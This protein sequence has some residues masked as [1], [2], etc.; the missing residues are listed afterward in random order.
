MQDVQRNSSHGDKNS[1]NNG[2]NHQGSSTQSATPHSHRDSVSPNVLTNGS[3]RKIAIPVLVKDGK[4]CGDSSPLGDSLSP[5]PSTPDGMGAIEVSPAP[6]D[7][8][9][10]VG[11]SA[12]APQ[13]W[14]QPTAFT[15]AGNPA[16]GGFAGTTHFSAAASGMGYSSMSGAVGNPPYYNFSAA[17]PVGW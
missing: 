14:A 8:K 7:L 17:R 5:D 11:L 2:N 1:N 13:G 16:F 9:L 4:P 12:P 3:P 10:N 6:S 15:C